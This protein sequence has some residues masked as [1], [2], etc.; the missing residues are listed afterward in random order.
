MRFVHGI[1]EKCLHLNKY[2]SP[3]CQ[4]GRSDFS[5]GFLVL[6]EADKL[7]ELGLLTQTDEIIAAC[8]SKDLHKALFSAT[9]PAAVE[10]LARSVMQDPLRIIIGQKSAHRLFQLTG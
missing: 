4:G 8:P 5:V 7:F 2:L 10:S 3:F 9:I 1:N 6:D